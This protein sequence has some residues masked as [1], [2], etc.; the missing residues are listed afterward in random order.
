MYERYLSQLAH[1]KVITPRIEASLR[2]YTDVLGLYESGRDGDSAVPAR[3]G[4]A[5]LPH[6]SSWSRASSR[7]SPISAGAPRVPSQL[8]AAVKRI[9]ATG[10]GIG[11]LEANAGHGRPIAT[12]APAATSTRCS[13]TSTRFKATGKDG[14][15]V[16]EPAAALQP[17]RRR[18]ALASTTSPSPRPTS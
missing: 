14:A 4:R 6:A 5:F 18:R 11:W 17:A 15:A 7:R 1:V 16:P 10:A 13:G 2:F 3:L 9:E 8:E 12:A